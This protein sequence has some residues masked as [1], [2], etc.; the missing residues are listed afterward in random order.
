MTKENPTPNVAYEAC[1]QFALPLE[2]PF[3]FMYRFAALYLY[4]AGRLGR[5][6]KLFQISFPRCIVSSAIMFLIP[7]VSFGCSQ[8]I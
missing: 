7:G 3:P 6:G 5:R 4:W 8:T 1:E 2:F